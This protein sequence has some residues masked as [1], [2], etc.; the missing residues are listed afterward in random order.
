MRDLLPVSSACEDLCDIDDTLRDATLA[1][2]ADFAT[3]RSKFALGGC[4]IDAD[5]ASFG[6]AVMEIEVLCA[7]AS[8]VQAAEAEIA[9]VADLVGAKPLAQA[10]WAASLRRTSGGP[11]V[12]QAL[13]EEGILSRK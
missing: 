12:L 5:T 11:K 10:R 7:D 4:S 9:R 1:P 2:F 8:G 6:H 3:T 13:V